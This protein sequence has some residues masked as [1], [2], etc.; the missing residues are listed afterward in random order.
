LFIGS[1]RCGITT[2]RRYKT[3]DVADVLKCVRPHDKPRKLFSERSLERLAAALF[4]GRCGLYFPSK[5]ARASCGTHLGFPQRLRFVLYFTDEREVRRVIKAAKQLGIDPAQAL[6][7]RVA[8]KK[9][10]VGKARTEVLNIT[11][12][13]LSPPVCIAKRLQRELLPTY[14][15]FNSSVAFSRFATDRYDRCYA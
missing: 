13:D 1:I 14:S 12:G 6:R 5:L 2:I 7:Q 3:R 10:A 11:D 15:F 4:R 8:F 9:G